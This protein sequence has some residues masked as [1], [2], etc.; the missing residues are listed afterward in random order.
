MA[1]YLNSQGT[2]ITIDGPEVL[3]KAIKE[4][5]E[6]MMEPPKKKSLEIIVNVKFVKPEAVPLS[7]IFG[8]EFL[9]EKWL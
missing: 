4:A 7:K 5:W 3:E 6:R 9:K 1:A 8:R 2:F